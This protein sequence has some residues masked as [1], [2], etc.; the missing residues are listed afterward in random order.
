MMSHDG[1]KEASKGVVG[2]LYVDVLIII[3]IIGII[4]FIAGHDT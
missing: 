4:V 1:E 2:L 3:I